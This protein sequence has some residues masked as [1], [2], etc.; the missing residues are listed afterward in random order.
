MLR[1]RPSCKFG[2]HSGEL[3]RT[4]ENKEAF[5]KI[6]RQVLVEGVPMAPMRGQPDM[7]KAFFHAIL[8]E[9]S[10]EGSRVEIDIGEVLPVEAW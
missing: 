1:I 2:H 6:R 9:K 7:Y 8:K 3:A 5:D 10:K 4:L